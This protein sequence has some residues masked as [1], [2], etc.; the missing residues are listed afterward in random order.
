MTWLKQTWSKKAVVL[1]LSIHFCLWWALFAWF[2]ATSWSSHLALISVIA[3]V[4]R[5]I[6]YFQGGYWFAGIQGIGAFIALVGLSFLALRTR[7]R[8]IVLLAHASVLVYWFYSLFLIS[9]EI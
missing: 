4:S 8:W 5:G 7:T 3:P 9:I 1:G 2:W 6:F